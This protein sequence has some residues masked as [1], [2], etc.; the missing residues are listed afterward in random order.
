M[1]DRAA[2]VD[3]TLPPSDRHPNGVQP[4]ADTNSS[5]TFALAT[6]ADN[7]PIWG[8]DHIN[9]DAELRKFWPTESYLASAFGSQI[10]RYASFPWVLDGPERMTTIYDS[11]LNGCENGAGWQTMMIKFVTDLYTQSNGAFLEVIRTGD[12]PTSPVVSLRHMD[13]ARCRRTGLPDTPVVF[14]DVNWK[15]HL[16]KWYQVIEFSEM[17]SPQLEFR[18]LQLCVLDRILKAAQIMKAIMQF[19]LEKVSGSRHHKMH[20]IGG[21]NQDLLESTMKQKLA[22]ARASGYQVYVDPVVLAALNPDGRVTHEEIDLNGLPEDFN[23]DIFMKWYIGN[24][25]LS[26]EDEYQSFFPLPGGN[27]GTAQQSQ[28]MADKA[29]SKGP[30]IF[31][32]L[33]EHKFN[34][35]GVLPRTVKFHFGEQDP[36]AD[37][38]KLDMF[39]RFSATL[40]NLLKNGA[41]TTQVAAL[42][43]RDAGYLKPEYLSM[44]GIT[45]DITPQSVSS[46][47]P[48]TVK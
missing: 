2:M 27:L 8:Y 16:L 38:A 10:G 34:Y 6:K 11:I 45:T 39:W 46:E 37:Q 42:M 14:W 12:S 4:V 9:R 23:E 7:F 26:W 20:L 19:K 28:T 3:F 48:T 35:Y 44:L 31:M 41:I 5:F 47:D 21:F 17:P 40:A 25:A 15:S 18:G 24:I 36:A 29:R 13:A 22:T 32:R 43:M 1:L 33:L 30:A